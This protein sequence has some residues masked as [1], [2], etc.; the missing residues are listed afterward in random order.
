M[1]LWRNVQ[2]VCAEALAKEDTLRRGVAV[3]LLGGV[4]KDTKGTTAV[5][6]RGS[7]E[8]PQHSI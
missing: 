7:T 3:R 4:A 2:Q 6:P 1:K 5:K 8:G